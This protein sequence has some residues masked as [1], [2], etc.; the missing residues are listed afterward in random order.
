MSMTS[1][2]HILF[3]SDFH[4]LIVEWFVHTKLLWNLEL[5]RFPTSK[6]NVKKKYLTN[7]K[8]NGVLQN[9]IYPAHLFILRIVKLGHT[10]PIPQERLSAQVAL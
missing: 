8:N 6:N 5:Q 2:K 4:L 10:A 3:L 9:C 1:F 7:V